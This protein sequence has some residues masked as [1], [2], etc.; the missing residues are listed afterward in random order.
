MKRFWFKIGFICSICIPLLSACKKESFD[1]L[2]PDVELFVQELKSGEYKLP[3]HEGI[4][5]M[6]Q[7]KMDDIPYLLKYADDLTIIPS[8]PLALTTSDS[9]LRL[10]ECILWTIESIRIGRDASLGC[11]LVY[12]NA[13]NYEG[14]YYLSDDDLKQ[15]CACYRKW[16]EKYSTQKVM[17]WD[18]D[19]CLNNPLC[20]TPFMW[21]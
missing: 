10:G 13:D 21:W 19:F 16:W 3:E 18:D 15:A 8:F 20:G 2:N 11:K 17:I 12:V 5:N 14:I 4:G 9:K 1:Y 6:P 7:F